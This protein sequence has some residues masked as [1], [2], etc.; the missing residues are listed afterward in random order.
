MT[1]GREVNTG[2]III[3]TNTQRTSLI[4]KQSTTWLAEYKRNIEARSRNHCS[5][6]KNNKYYI[7]WVLVCSLSYPARRTHKPYYDVIWQLSASIIFFH[8]SHKCHNFR[9][10][11]L[12]NIK[13]VLTFFLQLSKFKKNSG[14][15]SEAGFSRSTAVSLSQYHSFQWSVIIFMHKNIKCGSG[16]FTSLFWN[17]FNCKKNSTRYYHKCSIHLHVKYQWILNFKLSPCSECCL[18]SFGWIPGVWFTYADVSEQYKLTFPHSLVS[19]HT[20]LWRW[21][22]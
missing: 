1:P 13:C 10:K 11:N 17:L 19:L 5:R 3:C 8:I 21:N 2:L 15:D 4:L 16:I 22:R 20:C 12:L 14:S 9:G 18:F 6:G 7:F